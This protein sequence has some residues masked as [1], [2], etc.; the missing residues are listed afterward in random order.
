M[1]Q[2]FASLSLSLSQWSHLNE[3]V[4]LFLHSSSSFVSLILQSKWFLVSFKLTL[5]IFAASVTSLRNEKKK[6]NEYSLSLICRWV[7]QR[8]SQP[9]TKDTSLR[10]SQP[11]A[12]AEKKEECPP[13]ADII[14]SQWIIRHFKC[15]RSWA[16][17]LSKSRVTARHVATERWKRQQSMKVICAHCESKSWR[18]ALSFIKIN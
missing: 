2:H 15:R 10:S 5:T 13:R 6:R 1:W 8:N 18:S 17:I 14:E 4:I 16:F 9:L 12:M 3:W 11:C 7:L